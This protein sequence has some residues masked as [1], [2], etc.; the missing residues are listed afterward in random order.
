M[1]NKK[2][3][4]FFVTLI[5]MLS[6]SSVAAVE[7]NSTDDMSIGDAEEE[8]P[9][10]TIMVDSIDENQTYSNEVLKAGFIENVSQ[11]SI[12]SA[13]D[14]TNAL[15][16]DGAAADEYG[17]ENVLLTSKNTVKD[18]IDA[19]DF[20]K[21]Y[22][23]NSNYYATFYD[24]NGNPLADTNITFIFNN[25][26]YFTSMTDSE[27][28]AML[29]ITATVGTHTIT[30]VNPVTGQSKTNK[31]TVYNS[32]RANDLEKRYRSSQT[33]SATFYGLDEKVYADKE[34]TFLFNNHLVLR[35]VTDSN[36]VARLPIT[37]SVGTHTIVSINP[38]TGQRI[39]NKITVLPNLIVTKSWTT[40]SDRNTKLVITLYDDESLAKN[41]DVNVYVNGVKYQVKT[42]SKGVA[43]YTFKLSKGTYEFKSQDPKTG[44][45]VT[46]D[47][48]VLNPT[49]SAANMDA[50]VNTDSTYTAT[51]LNPDGTV[52][53][54][55]DMQITLNGKTSTVKTNSKGVA[56]LSFNLAKGTYAVTCKDLNTGYTI[57]RTITVSLTETKLASSA[58]V[59]YNKY[60]VSSDGKTILAIGRAS[61]SGEYSKYGYTFYVTE[62]E[63][64]CSCCGG[65]NLYWGIFWAGNEYTNYATF[66]GTGLK[67]GSSAEGAIFCADCDSDWSVFGH[68]HGGSGGDLTVVTKTAASTKAAA[69]ELKS[70]NYVKS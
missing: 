23:S 29:K 12:L 49:I 67:E 1:F 4:L 16:G 19:E 20:G 53:S 54:N 18:T 42:D 28:V 45:A 43:Y 62:F 55:T 32:V 37:A 27:G 35:A 17:S 47:I 13:S 46:T 24:S 34:V 38:V 44:Y 33:F 59:T 61:A 69:Y 60:G 51:L 8:P 7:M 65:H 25:R 5:F 70:G 3:K 68:N 63:R 41:A 64:T 6:I 31:I 14:N 9:S 39:T 48:K 26:L 66:P 22:R 57:S 21:R 30:S 58:P 11:S 36:G 56:S 52:C 40:F 2:I 50:A 15:N 10:G